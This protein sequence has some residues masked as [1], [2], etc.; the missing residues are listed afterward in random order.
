VR[1][2]VLPGLTDGKQVIGPSRRKSRSPSSE[3][4]KKR[5][6]LKVG[7]TSLDLK[8]TDFDPL[9]KG[10][11]CDDPTATA[12]ANAASCI[13]QDIV[14]KVSGSFFIVNYGFEC[15]LCVAQRAGGAS[16]RKAHPRRQVAS[17][18]LHQ[19]SVVDSACTP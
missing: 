17:L 15:Q 14:D 6:K 19:R 3:T 8:T 7:A 11:I 13:N 10:F 16:S 1:A 12:A 2:A 9:K 5:K 4:S 18:Q